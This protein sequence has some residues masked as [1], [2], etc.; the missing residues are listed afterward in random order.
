MLLR[1][2][3]STMVYQKIGTQLDQPLKRCLS[4]IY[5]YPILT[6]FCCCCCLEKELLTTWNLKI[7]E[8]RTDSGGARAPLGPFFLSY[9]IFN[10]Y[11]WAPFQNLRLHL[12]SISLANLTQIATIKLKNLTKTI[13]AFI[14]VIV[15]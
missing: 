11:N 7:V 8:S 9:Y 1:Q 5:I 14:M 6:T 4:F 3:N 2:S 12:Y 10:F 15:F 13:K